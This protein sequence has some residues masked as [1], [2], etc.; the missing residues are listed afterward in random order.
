MEALRNLKNTKVISALVKWQNTVWYPIVFA[1]LG[2]VSALFGVYAYAPIFYIYTVSVLF[3]VLFN[4]DLKVYFTPLFLIFPT[5]GKDGFVTFDDAHDNT[6]GMF[7]TAGFVQMAVCASIMIV[8]FIVKLCVTGAIKDVFKKRS[9]FGFGLLVFAGACLLNGIFSPSWVAMDIVYGILEAVGVTVVYFLFSAVAMRSEDV[10][11]YACK[12]MVIL[13]F[14]IAAEVG[15]LSGQLAARGE[16]FGENGEFIRDSITFGWGVN[17]IVGC[18]MALPIPAAMY[19]AHSRKKGTFAYFAA[20][21]F[22]IM[23]VYIQARNAMLFGALSLLAGAIICCISGKN[24]VANRYFTVVLVGLCI[25]AFAFIL[26]RFDGFGGLIE[27][28]KSMNFL[29]AGSGDN[30]RIERWTNGLEDFR[31]S[32][33]F[34]VGFVDGSIPA[35]PDPNGPNRQS[36]SVYWNM[37]HNIFIQLIGSMGI[38]GLLCF[39]VHVKKL[40]E[41]VCT[42]YSAEKLLLFLLPVSLILM[43]FLDIYFFLVNM[44]LYYGGFLA[45]IEKRNIELRAAKTENIRCVP[46]GAKP[47]V[48]LLSAKEVKSETL[49]AFK[50]VCGNDVEVLELRISDGKLCARMEKSESARGFKK[51]MHRAARFVLGDR[52]AA[53]WMTC[54]CAK[55]ERSALADMNV[56]AVIATDFAAAQIAAGLRG[57]KQPYVATVSNAFDGRMNA[58]VNDALILNEKEY[59]KADSVRGYA[60]GHTV[61]VGSAE[62]AA[63]LL[64]DKVMAIPHAEKSERLD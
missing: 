12:V 41:I 1:A 34:G 51:F 4:D 31:R 47:R 36:P 63:K 55:K 3:A 14:M 48:A 43:S 20:V 44:Q 9:T 49:E 10:A 13:G 18:M 39:L 37:Y 42:D 60:C 53:K 17:T 7:C 29:H 24:R 2:V 15:G 58:N 33:V 30:G 22:F 16:L 52:L 38:V 27:K 35:V 50:A 62:E 54:G 26:K 23:L 8:L 19:L 6:M 56:D 57:K 28:L 5:V 46:Y 25:V 45:V 21:L 59:R 40:I 32:P 61:S 64:Y 11:G